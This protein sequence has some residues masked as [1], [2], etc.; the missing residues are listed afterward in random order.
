[1]LKN[2]PKRK[3]VKISFLENTITQKSIVKK[4][5]TIELII[6]Y[7]YASYTS[8]NPPSTTIACPVT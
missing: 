4:Q 8:E 3:V 5:I 1:M 6:I 2:N 7:S